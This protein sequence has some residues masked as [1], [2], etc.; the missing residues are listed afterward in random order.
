LKQ[1]EILAAVRARGRGGR[2]TQSLGG[3]NAQVVPTEF[4]PTIARTAA[5]GSKTASWAE[6]LQRQREAER[7]APG[8]EGDSSVPDVEREGDSS[9]PDTQSDDEDENADKASA[10]RKPRIRRTPKTSAGN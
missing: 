2:I 7:L 8:K 6:K 3:G 10:G 4:V 1:H 9:V 5:S